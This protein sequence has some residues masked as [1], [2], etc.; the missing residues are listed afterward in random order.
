[1]VL[2][3]APFAVGGVASAGEQTST[4]AQLSQPPYVD[5]DDWPP[6]G[7]NEVEFDWCQNLT[8]LK[9]CR[10]A[11]GD[12]GT[13][14]IDHA[15]NCEAAGDICMNGDEA[16]AF[17]HCLW[18]SSLTLYHGPGTARGFLERHEAFSNGDDDSRRDWVNNDTGFRVAQEAAVDMYINS[19]LTRKEAV[20]E[21]CIDLVRTDQ[22]EF[23]RD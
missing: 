3:L 14:A 18:S 10:S 23:V 7:L 8:R 4:V 9:I 5:D 16:N 22:L 12:L 13:W 11:Y 1:M 2:A 6:A 20:F 17:Q 19:S 21:R 15:K